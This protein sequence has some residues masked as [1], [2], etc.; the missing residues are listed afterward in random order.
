MTL[1]LERKKCK[2]TGYF[3]LYPIGGLLAAA[4]P[5]VQ[6]LL[7][8]DTFTSQAASPMAVLLDANWQMMGMLN[9][10]V[11]ICGASLMYHTEYAD[12]GMQKMDVLPVRTGALFLGKC[13]LAAWMLAVMIAIETAA[14]VFCERYWFPAVS[15]DWRFVLPFALFQWI[16]A[17]PTVLLMLAIAS[18]CK[19][20]WISLGIGVI[21]VFTMSIFLQES[22][23]LYYLPFASPYLTWDTVLAGGRP[24]LTLG[25]FTAESI[26]AVLLG[27]LL[28]KIRR[29]L[30]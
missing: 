4:F 13:A 1:R 6:M 24:A 10:L 14:L 21:L 2:R 23:T 27:L 8:A 20:M 25:V 17:L 26:L 7:R 5:V 15:L 12:H 29:C 18:V 22:S 19:N 9:M 16:A 30:M 28:Q 11:S 3:Y